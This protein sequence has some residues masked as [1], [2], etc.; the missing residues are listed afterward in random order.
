MYLQYSGKMLETRTAKK[1]WTYHSDSIDKTLLP[2]KL[3]EY[4]LTEEEKIIQYCQENHPDLVLEAG[5][6][7]GRIIKAITP[8][9]KKIIGI[10]YSPTMAMFCSERFKGNSNI[11]IYE[12]DISQTHFQDTYFNLEILAFNTLGNTDTNKESVLLELKRVLRPQGSLL[13]S[14]YSEKARDIQYDTYQKLSLN[15]LREE[16]DRIYTRE[17][18][19][20]QRFSVRDLEAWL[21]VCG[22]KGIIEPL[23]D[24]S[25]FVIAKKDD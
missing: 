15:I 13:V 14:V 23:N 5:C 9:C 3:K 8:H 4:L 21:Q 18:L 19:V 24:I 16:N 17:G 22:L 11:K 20:S 25:Y 7:R 1:F 6:G 2:E 10:D 12:E